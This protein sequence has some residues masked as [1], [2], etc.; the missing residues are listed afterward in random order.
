MGQSFCFDCKEQ[1]TVGVV[2]RRERHPLVIIALLVPIIGYALCAPL[3][4]ITSLIGLLLGLRVL[5]ELRERPNYT[6]RS[7]ALAALV[8]SGGTLATWVV[9]VLAML[10]YYMGVR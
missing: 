3:L 5:K 10:T 6:G 1:V 8:I 2:E 7:A 9:G 4:P